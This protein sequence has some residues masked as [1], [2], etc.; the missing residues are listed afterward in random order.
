M[1]KYIFTEIEE[2][3]EWFSWFGT[4]I[5]YA[6]EGLGK[7]LM[8]M[9]RGDF[10]MVLE[11]LIQLIVSALIVT[12]MLAVSILGIAIAALGSLILGG[13]YDAVKDIEEH[14]LKSWEAVN[15][16]FQ[17]IG[18]ML[19]VVGLIG[20]TLVWFSSG[21]W[22]ASLGLT[23]GHYIAIA[24]SGAILSNL[25]EFVSMGGRA[26]DF[27]G[28]HT[29]GVVNSNMQLVGERGAELVS[30]PRGSRVHSNADSKRMLG[31][32]GGNTI[33]VHVN[34]RVGASDAEIRDIANKV[35][36]EINLRM[37]R[38]GSGVNNF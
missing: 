13:I 29:G 32:S 24:I 5:V 38:T 17:S 22:L 16:I 30:L 2:I 26:L 34:G 15:G 19:L 12:I 18:Q 6:F 8:G 10:A 9:F 7:I 21:A 23:L 33:N 25:K 4:F 31:S 14:G 3:Q 37:S 27:V 1:F 36:R 35:A 11:G 28:L 20:A